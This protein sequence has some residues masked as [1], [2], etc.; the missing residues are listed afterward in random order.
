M[1]LETFDLSSLRLP[2]INPSTLSSI[3]EFDVSHNRLT[4]LPGLEAL[5]SLVFLDLCRNE[6]RSLPSEL[7]VMLK[8]ERLKASRNELRPNADFLVLL[9]SKKG[10]GE[11]D[12]KTQSSS[13][14]SEEEEQK[15]TSPISSLYLPRLAF[16]DLTFN[17]KCFTLD[18]QT[19]LSSKLPQVS[20]SIT[21]TS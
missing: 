15:T 21:V 18:L 12:K 20:V 8:L 11:G 6:F 19:L 1:D 3:T 7:K 13:P 4:S 14:S 9:L 5:G 2:L 16:L 17:K 10:E